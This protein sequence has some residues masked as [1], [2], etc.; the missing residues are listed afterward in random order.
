[1]S[2][3]K[4]KRRATRKKSRGITL[5]GSLLLIVSIFV[6]SIGVGIVTPPGQFPSFTGTIVW[7]WLDIFGILALIM[8]IIALIGVLIDTS[9]VSMILV[10]LGGVIGLI[11][12]IIDLFIFLTSGIILALAPSCAFLG[13]LLALLGALRVRI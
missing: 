11:V 2:K 6:P 4:S 7:P 5:V 13:G 12:G 1:M 9:D 10:V 3:R 8:G